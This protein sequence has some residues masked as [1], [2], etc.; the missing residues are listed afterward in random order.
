MRNPDSLAKSD[1]DILVVGGGI[2][3]ACTA[4]DA[5]QRGLSVALVE[6]ADF[7]SA[8]SA[9]SLKILHG[10]IRY[11]QHLDVKRLRESCGE[12]A[13]FL[14]I[15]P[16]LTRPFS[17]AVP[18]YG[19]GMQG[20][21]VFRVAM[22]L[23][24][25]LTIDRNKGVSDPQRRI[26]AGHTM[27]RRDT[28]AKYPFVDAG[29]L[30]GAACLYDGQILNPP[31]MVWSIVRSAMQIGASVCN[32]CEISGLKTNDGR[33]SGA[34]AVDKLNNTLFE[35]RAKAVINATGPYAQTFVANAT[36]TNSDRS[37]LSR[38][39]A[40]VIR[41]KIV[42]DTAI[43]IQTKYKDPDAFLSRGNRHIFLVPWRDY[44]LIGV[45]SRT[46][47]DNPYELGVTENEIQGFLDEINEALPSAEV[48]RDEIGVVYA[49]LLPFG[50]NSPDATDLSF[51]KRSLIIDHGLTSD[52]IKGLYSAAS[53]RWTMGRSTA[54]DAVDKAEKYLRNKTT[55]CKTSQTPIFGGDF[56]LIADI[57]DAASRDDIG[58][59]LESDLL[60]HLVFNYGADWAG[61][62]ELAR[63]NP[64]LLKRVSNTSVIGAEIAYAAQSEMAVALEDCL[65][66][67]TDIGTG[68]SPSL[69]TLT[70]S[71]NILAVYL[72]WDES[73][74]RGEI[75][76]VL[77][78]YPF[79]GADGPLYS[80]PAVA[81][82]R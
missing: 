72:G 11:L 79:F 55:P 17:F 5:A 26:P 58:S 50:D 33:I 7:S 31:R 13:T 61:P 77:S 60:D 75:E 2:T 25:L 68:E 44:T 1:F 52:G 70:E 80:E 15:A 63:Q 54:E 53:V 16:H 35:I 24:H 4:W 28:L 10:G 45:N 22:L 62:I 69:Q 21:F 66:R 34:V 65:L 46:Y 29:G 78:R 40:F 43:A 73:R 3:G 32:Y 42:T 74:K 8:T 19:F 6:R 76:S 56:S 23:N 47:D 82:A 67:R 59:R 9:Q 36:A 20:K 48:R 30:T 71:A 81:Q 49:G 18:T 57:R 41:R 14:R 38:D 12:R 64:E 51:G 39:M 37:P 27:T